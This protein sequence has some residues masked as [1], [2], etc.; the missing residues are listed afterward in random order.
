MI[1]L[2]FQIYV[3]WDWATCNYQIKRE[4]KWVGK[5][6]FFSILSM[7]KLLFNSIID[8]QILKK[9]YNLSKCIIVDS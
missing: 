4:Q 1:S 7:K 6:I 5:R 9:Q 8:F 3:Y 2:Y